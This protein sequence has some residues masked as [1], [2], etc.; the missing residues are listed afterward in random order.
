LLVRSD[1]QRRG[2]GRTLL[3]KAIDY[4]RAR[5]TAQLIGQIRAENEPM[6]ALARRCGM[7]VDVAAGATLAV[8]HIDLRASAD[9]SPS[10]GKA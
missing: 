9:S 10:G 5:G 4:C 1:L 6:I 2:I 7:Q 8:A 3:L